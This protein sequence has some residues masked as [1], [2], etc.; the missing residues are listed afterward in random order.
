MV[1]QVIQ[2]DEAAV[3]ENTEMLLPTIKKLMK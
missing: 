3:K 2:I 1:R